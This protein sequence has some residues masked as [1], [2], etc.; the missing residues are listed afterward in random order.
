MLAPFWQGVTRQRLL[1]EGLILLGLLAAGGL[2]LWLD[3]PPDDGS[4]SGKQ[5]RAADL[6]PVE[7]RPLP[8]SIALSRDNTL[9]LVGNA[10]GTC[11]LWDLVEGR[12]LTDLAKTGPYQAT[13]EVVLTPDSRFAVV[14]RTLENTVARWDLV[15]DR[16][17]STLFLRPLGW[18]VALAFSADGRR[19]LVGTNEAVVDDPR[20]AGEWREGG[21]LALVRPAA[22]P[23]GSGEVL[24][25]LAMGGSQTGTRFYDFY[26]RGSYPLRGTFRVWDIA[27]GRLLYTLLEQPGCPV[28]GAALSLDGNRAL[29]ATRKGADDELK[30]WD[31]V[32]GKELRTFTKRPGHATALAFSPDA[33][34][35]LTGDTDF[36]IRVWEVSTGQVIRTFNQTTTFWPFR[37]LS[38]SPDSK[39]VL[40]GSGTLPGRPTDPQ[41]CL[42]ECKLWDAAT[43]REVRTLGDSSRAVLAARFTPDGKQVLAATHGLQLWDVATGQV[44]QTLGE[45]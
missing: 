34:R 36:R 37:C 5:W 7:E 24:A 39:W 42:G 16:H 23:G 28:S 18:A 25:Y 12:R 43:G 8:T 11:T 27:Q 3:P 44:V 33:T 9:A 15:T 35:V 38:L 29:T 2:W 17:Q 22:N 14:G 6:P 30:L 45:E 1:C 26:N 4:E 40:S 13:S 21:L 32:S 19:L 31:A 20:V 41:P 10:D